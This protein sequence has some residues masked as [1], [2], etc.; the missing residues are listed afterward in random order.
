[1]SWRIE[2]IAERHIEGFRAGVDEV[3]RERRYLSFLE[4]PSVEETR[5]F[6][7]GNITNGFPAF[8]AIAGEIVVGWSDVIPVQRPV[9]SHCG[10]L[11]MGVVPRWRR[12]G[13]GRALLAH[14]LAASRDYGLERV[15]LTV[16]AS[17]VHA[18]ALYKAHGFD[19]EG[20][21]RKGVLVDGGYDDLLCMT[22][23]H[24]QA[25]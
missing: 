3:A 1:M 13:I 16:R 23:I 9:H 15:E 6:V 2:R 24:E 10:V 7:L 14:A 22:V 5:R 4:A 20:V 18:I 17:N 25:A 11:G 21:K 12:Q 8:V 19:T